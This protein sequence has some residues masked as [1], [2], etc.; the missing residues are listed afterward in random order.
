[1]NATLYLVLGG[2]IG[3][4]VTLL[5]RM[6]EPLDVLL[7][8]GLGIIGAFLAGWIFTPLFGIK[9]VDPS[10]FNVTALLVSLAGTMILLIVV[11]F[12]RWGSGQRLN[13]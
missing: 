7:N 13:A 4:L 2:S 11:N 8:I 10:Y 5:L 3:L 1:M 9:T 6:R 12:L